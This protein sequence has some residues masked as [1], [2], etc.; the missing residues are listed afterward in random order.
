MFAR[1]YPCDDSKNFTNSAD[2]WADNPSIQGV[3]RNFTIYK[4]ME[5]GVLSE[6]TGNLFFDNFVIAES[7]RAGIE[8]Y[9][10][11]HTKE[12]PG[13]NNSA[14]IGVSDTN[15]HSDNVNYSTSS[16]LW[17]GRSGPITFKNVSIHNYIGNSYVLK[18]CSH[19]DD[20]LKY[21]NRG[22]DVYLEGISITNVTNYLLMVGPGIKREVIHD[23]DGSF[24][25]GFD[26]TSRPS[27]TIV[28]YWPHIHHKNPSVCPNATTPA[29]WDNA[30][31]CDNTVSLRRVQFTNMDKWQDF[32]VLRMKAAELDNI[33]YFLPKD[34][35]LTTD[36]YTSVYHRMDG[37]DMDSKDKGYGW[38]L[39]FITG[40]AYNIWWGDGV[41]WRHM[42]IETPPQKDDWSNGGIIFK[43][44]NTQQREFYRVSFRQGTG[45]ISTTPTT[46]V[47]KS[48]I[49]PSNFSIE[50]TDIVAATCQNGEHISN[51]STVA[52]IWQTMALCISDK[53]TKGLYQPWQYT[54]VDATMCRYFC[55]TFGDDFA[56]DNITRYW[57]DQKAWYK[58]PDCAKN[59]VKANLS[60]TSGDCA[61]ADETCDD[62]CELIQYNDLI[63]ATGRAKVPGL[64][65]PANPDNVY[66][67]G[68][69]RFFLDINVTIRNLTVMGILSVKM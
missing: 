39:P 4:C 19:C 1:T 34:A 35:T 41:D 40:K 12:A 47:Y 48:K 33:T 64:A 26:S 25:Q 15:P 11:N 59:C 28:H 50:P 2:P 45:V 3:F 7:W 32:K 49:T 23:L 52:E 13:L 10:S 27:G 62:T 17:T 51:F 22:N 55:P 43:F 46:G 56:V 65:D 30:I 63:Q 16:A 18:T 29:K 58:L 31:Y 61:W 42:A 38:S 54:Q 21:T 68:S 20:P 5:N 69:Y 57:S 66:I 53:N 9:T 67:S 60:C 36:Q 6:D 44:N 37:T 24:S 8:F 14:V